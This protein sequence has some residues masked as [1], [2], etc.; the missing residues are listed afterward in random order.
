[1]TSYRKLCNEWTDDIYDVNNRYINVTYQLPAMKNYPSHCRQ[2][3]TSVLREGF[4][5]N[6]CKKTEPGTRY[7]GCPCRNQ[8]GKIDKSLCGSGNCVNAFCVPNK[9]NGEKGE[10]CNNNDQCISSVCDGY[11]CTDPSCLSTKP[12]TRYNG[13]PCIGPGPEYKPDPGLCGSN[14]CVNKVCVPNKGNGETG[15]Y[16]NKDDQCISLVCDGYKCTGPD[17]CRTSK[18][19]R[20]GQKCNASDLH[21]SDNWSGKCGPITGDMVTG[22][23][24]NGDCSGYK[25]C[26]DGFCCHE[27]GI[28]E[29]IQC[30]EWG[31][32]NT[33]EG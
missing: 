11:K 9:G 18:I 12:G 31:K 28:G 26:A 16:C 8:D 14:Y 20:D 17:M 4:D 10:Y 30:Y 25:T 29:A 13:C 19:C 5:E 32:Q 15:E 3:S 7:N 2:K 23:Y 24:E 6:V 21:Q 27:A 33:C 1:M 22:K